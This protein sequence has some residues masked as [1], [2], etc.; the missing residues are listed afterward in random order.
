MPTPTLKKSQYLT[1]VQRWARHL[2][3]VGPSRRDFKGLEQLYRESLLFLPFIPEG[4]RV[5]DVGSGMGFPGIPLALERPDVHMVLLEP[6]ARRAAFLRHIVLHL[7][8]PSVEVVEGPLETYTPPVPLDRVVV[9]A[10]P[11]GPWKQLKKRFRTWLA[12]G[13]C[14][15]RLETRREDLDDATFLHPAE[16][17]FWIGEYR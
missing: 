11:S 16:E 14:L 8:L 12:P 6:R 13:G 4:S 7:S 1:E 10:L 17:G 5:L 2:S 15:L 3:L 9:R